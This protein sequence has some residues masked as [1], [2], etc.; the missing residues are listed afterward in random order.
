MF[1]KSLEVIFIFLDSFYT[2]VDKISDVGSIFAGFKKHLQPLPRQTLSISLLF[3]NQ[4]LFIEMY[5]RLR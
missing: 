3:Q 1:V 4:T 2:N 5:F